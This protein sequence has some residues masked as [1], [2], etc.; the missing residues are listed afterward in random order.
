MLSRSNQANRLA[1]RYLGRLR[2]FGLLM[3][4]A[5]GCGPTRL[6]PNDS[7]TRETVL[8][9]DA[10]AARLEV[11]HGE[12]RMFSGLVEPAQEV[13]LSFGRAGRIAKVGMED[14]DTAEAQQIL[15]ELDNR[16]LEKKRDRLVDARDKAQR[17]LDAIP[18]ASSPP[19]M[20]QLINGL[21]S[22]QGQARELS[23]RLVTAAAANQ[24]QPAETEQ[25]LQQLGQQISAL[26]ISASERQ[27]AELG[28]VIQDL[29]AQIDDVTLE[30]EDGLLLAPFPGR[31]QL[32]GIGV[33]S[34]VS[35]GTPIVRIFD[36]S[37]LL[38]TVSI[39]ADV[40]A[41]LA[42]GTEFTVKIGGDHFN[43]KSKSIAPE[44]DRT[45][46]TRRVTFQLEQQAA[47]RVVPGVMA[48]VEMRVGSSESG[49]WLPRSAVIRDVQGLWAVMV[50]EPID[51]AWKASR[52]YVEL[53]RLEAD[54]VLVRGLLEEGDWVITHGLQRIVPGQGVR[55]Q[56]LTAQEIPAELIQP[57]NSAGDGRGEPSG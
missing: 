46:R 14:G 44:L 1:A 43:A 39:P 41:S 17:D 50:A 40:A 52:R 8:T 28:R 26:N 42:P 25:T 31:L 12:M 33:G 6:A 13:N 49:F 22:I 38:I 18:T 36:A 24:P 19:S 10:I 5:A 30:L 3:L 56:L 20:Q 23:N 35:P 15:A 11:S 53:I 54:R 57:P 2:Y 4:V 37:N 34:M 27:R 29:E 16:R 45:S 51:D 9:V 32:S 21:N 7:Q 48:S 55:P 47:T